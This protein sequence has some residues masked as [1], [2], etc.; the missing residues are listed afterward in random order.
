MTEIPS[1]DIDLWSD[2]NVLDPFPAYKELRDLARCLLNSH[3][4]YAVP[5][6]E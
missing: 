1:S 3:D 6:A 2:E 4:L 5:D